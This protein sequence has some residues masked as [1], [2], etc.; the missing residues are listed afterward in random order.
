MES[1][2]ALPFALAF[3]A[4]LVSACSPAQATPT[5]SGSTETASA[6]RIT[7]IMDGE[8]VQ[9]L[10]PAAFSRVTPITIVVNGVTKSGPAV[11]DVLG[12]L[13][14]VSYIGLSASGRSLEDN[15]ELFLELAEEHLGSEMIF[16]VDSG[17]V[18][19]FGQE[20]PPNYWNMEI[21]SLSLFSC[22]SCGV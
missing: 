17:A 16:T 5:Q 14:F 4:M 18:A 13:G 11:Q 1:T 21:T 10:D 2:K 8:E 6:S 20:I 3:L 12:E 19:L 9:K 15:S 22:A 7:V